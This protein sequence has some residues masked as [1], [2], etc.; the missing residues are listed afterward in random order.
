M[1]HI[2]LELSNVLLTV[3]E[4]ERAGSLLEIV[5]KIA[6]VKCPVVLEV[7]EVSVVEAVRKVHWFLIVHLPFSIECIVLPLPFVRQLGI[8]VEQLPES[9]H[10]SV[11]PVPFINTAISIRELPEAVPQTVFLVSGVDRTVFVLFCYL[12]VLV[13][14][15]WGRAWNS[16]GC[17]WLR[18]CLVELLGDL[19][20]CCWDLDGWFVDWWFIDWARWLNLSVDSGFYGL[21]DNWLGSWR[22]SGCVVLTN[23]ILLPVLVDDIFCLLL[24]RGLRYILGRKCWFCPGHHSL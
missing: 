1:H 21:V 8:R 3:D 11:F 7:V 6:V 9:V 23:T 10:C 12:L 13:L 4:L 15:F 2:L 5:D 20:Y 14:V 18:T 22:R 24:D 19:W 16:L 17:L